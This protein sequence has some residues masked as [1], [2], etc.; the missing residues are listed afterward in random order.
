M[1]TDVA[2][3]VHVQ[4][5]GFSVSS[6]RSESWVSSV[7]DIVDEGVVK[8]CVEGESEGG[9]GLVGCLKP[10]APENPSPEPIALQ[11]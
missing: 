6:G 10:P 9:V 7:D 11:V 1:L 3:T 4:R 2:Q 8:G 5:R